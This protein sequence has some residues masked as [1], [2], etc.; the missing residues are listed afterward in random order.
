MPRFEDSI[1]V[2]VP[3]RIAHDQWTQFED[4]PMFMEGVKELVEARRVPTGAW[5][6]EI[7]GDRVTRD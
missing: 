6:G 1:N 7:H 3:V 2:D 4:F 5:R